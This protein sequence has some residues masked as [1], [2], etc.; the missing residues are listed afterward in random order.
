MNA[1][2]DE[3]QQDEQQAMT[4]DQGQQAAQDQSSQAEPQQENQNQAPETS[5]SES[6]TQ[7]GSQQ[8]NDRTVSRGNDRNPASA[9]GSSRRREPSEVFDPGAASR[10]GLLRLGRHY[11]ESGSIY[12][13]IYAY[14]KVL[15]RYP[16]RGAASAAVE[17]MVLMA[18]DLM[19]QH[20]FYTALHIFDLLEE[21]M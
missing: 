20:K 12:G 7:G 6:Q 9:R 18:N 11:Q 16:G 13:A 21:L 1:E 19:D 2:N 10:V 8:Q 17:E 15:E 14:S 5:A 4:D 3:S